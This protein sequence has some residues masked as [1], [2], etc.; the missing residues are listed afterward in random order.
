MSQKLT[1]SNASL[2]HLIADGTT[3]SDL[4]KFW[5]VSVSSI[6]GWL[7]NEEAIMPFYAKVLVDYANH[8][9]GTIDRQLFIVSIPAKSA[10]SFRIIIKAFDGAINEV[11][12]PNV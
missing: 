5:G 11:D 10:E 12:L 8:V 6:H 9:N 1:V 7:K 2:R 4:S 3:P